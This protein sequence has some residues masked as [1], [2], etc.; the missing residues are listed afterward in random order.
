M[1]YWV[2]K[3]KSIP[4]H[5]NWYFFLVGDYRNHSLIN[6][7]FRD[8]FLVLSDRIGED[9]AIIAQNSSLEADLQDALK[10]IKGGTLGHMINELEQ[11]SPGLLVINKHPSML[12]RYN[13]MYKEAKASMPKEWSK[14]QKTKY[15]GDYY[16]HNRN[17]DELDDDAVILYIPFTSIEKAYTSTNALITDLVAFTKGIDNTFIKKT[18]KRGLIQ[19]KISTSISLNIGIVA[20]N[21]EIE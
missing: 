17:N 13:R 12:S 11:R 2:S 18:S 7:L 4:T 10:D 19:K 6:D 20:I 14:E 21:F 9:S 15:L 5:F 8:D 3:L 16:N 1:G